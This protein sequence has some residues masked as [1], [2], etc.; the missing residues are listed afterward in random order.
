MLSIR[1]F[2]HHG[3]S[4]VPRRSS[5][6]V[7][8]RSFLLIHH[9]DT[10]GRPQAHEQS[11]HRPHETLQLPGICAVPYLELT[12]EVQSDMILSPENV[13]ATIASFNGT[14]GCTRTLPEL[15][16]ETP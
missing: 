6:C 15:D 16:D 2:F 3:A 4:G 14:N 12:A 11:G 10:F 1:S 13:I 5:Q 7:P 8:A 9:F